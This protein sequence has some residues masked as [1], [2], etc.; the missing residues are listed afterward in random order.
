MFF[1][2]TS[3]DQFLAFV[4]FLAYIGNVSKATGA[5]T[6]EVYVPASG[7]SYALYAPTK[8]LL[9]AHETTTDAESQSGVTRRMARH[10]ALVD[11][12]FVREKLSPLAQGYV[13]KEA[14]IEHLLGH[15]KTK[16]F[17]KHHPAVTL[18]FFTEEFGEAVALENLIKAT[19]SPKKG[20]RE[21]A[22]K[23]LERIL[24]D[25]KERDLPPVHAFQALKLQELLKDYPLYVLKIDYFEKYVWMRI[26][27]NVRERLFWAN[28]VLGFEGEKEKVIEHLI[29]LKKNVNGSDDPELRDRVYGLAQRFLATLGKK[30]IVLKMDFD[31][32]FFHRLPTK[33][34]LEMLNQLK[35]RRR[36]QQEQ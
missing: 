22:G 10:L 14:Q 36:R 8:R 17:V 26:D 4:A 24:E 31:S 9:S 7:H 25:W 20:A 1:R 34:D 19:K 5:N 13:T 28:F 35:S 6:T 23:I 15:Q 21:T 29:S 12:N 3:I 27:E 30:D 16:Q 32:R 11:I 33:G 2:P 18:K